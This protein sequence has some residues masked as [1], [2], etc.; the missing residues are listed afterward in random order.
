MLG[1]DGRSVEHR[2]EAS[3]RDG[4]R[5]ASRQARARRRELRRRR[6]LALG[7]LAVVLAGDRRR[8]AV[9]SGGI[10]RP[11]HRDGSCAE[12]ARAR[13]ALAGLASGRGRCL[14]RE[15]GRATLR[16]RPRG[17]PG[18]AARA[19]PDV[20]RDR[21]AAGRRAVPRPVRAAAAVRRADAGARSSAGWHAVT[22]DQ[23]E[24]YWRHGV[25]LARGQAD[26]AELRQRLPVA[27]HAGA[28]GAA[29]TRL[30]RRG[31]HPAHR[32]AALAG[33]PLQCRDQGLVAAGWELD[34]QGISHADLITLDAQQLR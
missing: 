14:G 12:G 28:A 5:R 27:V 22:L 17:D 13:R 20:P 1:R 15:R 31:E 24:A 33:R 21:R 23:L 8:V 34:T 11:G 6:A 18:Q 10:G 30:G 19:N 26:R 29:A 2:A 4:H 32:A 25:P 7:A 16:R 3:A 9:G